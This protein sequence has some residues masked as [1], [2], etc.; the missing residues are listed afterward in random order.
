MNAGIILFNFTRMRHMVG[1]G[2]SEAIR[3]TW[4]THKKDLQ[5]VEQDILNVIFAKSPQYLYELPCDWNYHVFQCKPDLTEKPAVSRQRS[6]LN[7]CPSAAKVDIHLCKVNITLDIN[8]L[9]RM[10]QLS[11][12][13][14]VVHLDRSQYSKYIKLLKFQ[15]F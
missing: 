4:R 10:E 12:M 6:G 8:W 14:I 7:L 3:Y 1:G 13:G 9:F 5:L 15:H 11:C 2:F